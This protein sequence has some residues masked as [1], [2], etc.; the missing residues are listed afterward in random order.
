[1]LIQRIAI[2]SAVIVVIC[3]VSGRTFAQDSGPQVIPEVSG[4]LVNYDRSGWHPR[5]KFNANF[6]LG[7]SK[8]VPGNTDGLS[9]QLGYLLN[10]TADYLSDNDNHE[11][12]NAL[13]WELGYTKTPVVDTWIKSMDTIDFKTSYLYHL[14][15]PRWLGPFVSFRLTTAMLP[16]YE[17]RAAETNVVR[18]DPGDTVTEGP[19]GAPVNENGAFL[20]LRTFG[21][22]E[23]IDLTPAFSPLTLRESLGLFAKPSEKTTFT[24][25]ARLG[26]GAWETFVQNGYVLEDNEDTAFLELRRMTDTVQ[27][28]T[29]L[30]IVA[31]GAFHDDTV[32]YRLSALFMQPFAHNADTDLEGVDLMNR[33]FEAGLGVQLLDFLSINYSFKAYK[34]P[35][36]VNKWQIQNSLM[37]SIGFDLIGNPPPAPAEVPCDCTDAVTAATA[38]CKAERALSSEPRAPAAPS[39]DAATTNASD[40]DT[41]APADDGAAVPSAE[42]T[43]SSEEE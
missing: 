9:V 12:T 23:K 11:W 34:Q 31:N 39:E 36:I 33:E 14:P 35:L 24:L 20:P 3:S 17:V 10:G 22:G 25:D 42:E 2:F 41:S 37:L 15:K 18:L 38:K 29:E 8:N 30:G 19:S 16:S 13:L 5:L 1:M 28:G 6:A 43:A 4:T 7:Q 32:S 27:I 40:G 26:V 21:S